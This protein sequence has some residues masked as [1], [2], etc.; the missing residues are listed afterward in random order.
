[1]KAV[2]TPLR[3]PA[4]EGAEQFEL[5]FESAPDAI[6]V[7]SCDGRIRLANQEAGRMFGYPPKGLIGRSL[8]AILPAGY[9]LNHKELIARYIQD[10]VPRLVGKGL[11]VWARRRDGLEFPVEISLSP[12]KVAGELLISDFIRDLSGRR[13]LDQALREDQGRLQ[14]LLDVANIIPWEANAETWEFAYVGPQAEVILGYPVSRWYEPDFWTEHIHPDDR[15][16]ALE[17]CKRCSQ[18]RDD[19]QFEYRMVAADGKVVWLHD[20]VSVHSVDGRP[21]TL[22]G[23]MVDITGRKQAQLLIEENEQPMQLITDSLPV[24][25][26]YVDK[27]QRYQFNNRAHAEFIRI[28]RQELKGRRLDQVFGS[29]FE[30]MREDIEAALRGERREIQAQLKHPA[31]GQRQIEI[32]LVPDVADNG[33]VEGFYALGID[34]TEKLQQEQELRRRQDE[35]AHVSRVSTMGQ[36]AGSLAHELSQPLGAILTNARA[37]Q[38]FLGWERKDLSRAEREVCEALESIKQDTLRGGEIIRRLRN[39]LKKGRLR[40]KLLDVNKLLRGVRTLSRAYADSLDV[41]LDTHLQPVLPEVSGD[42]IQLEQVF[43]NLIRNGVEAVQHLPEKDRL[44]TLRSRLTDEQ[45]IDVAVRDNGTGATQESLQRMFDPFF[46]TKAKGLGM[47][48]SISHSIVEAPGGRLWAE[49][50]PDRGLTVHVSLPCRTEENGSDQ[51][52]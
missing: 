46:S 30:L 25:I 11:G 40:K 26:S 32:L 45:E 43:L 27:D 48:L 5:L 44:L 20:L 23:F 49:R 42:L 51:G 37:A 34:V 4:L 3:K 10:P 24:L 50:N 1:M 21:R 22:R 35:L 31:L 52:S 13:Q 47:G 17:F 8:A 6:I 15:D 9:R 28:P 36:F 7:V 16:R 41:T 39:L 12:L 29:R 38:E 18:D 2:K 33:S 14:S 19:Y